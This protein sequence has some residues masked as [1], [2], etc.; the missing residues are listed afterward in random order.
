[1]YKKTINVR[2]TALALAFVAISAVAQP[3]EN[4]APNYVQVKPGTTLNLAN[5]FGLIA[6]KTT[7]AELASK[8]QRTTWSAT[9]EGGYIYGILYDIQWNWIYQ[10]NQLL[11]QSK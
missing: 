1:M 8:L 3:A 10:G 7:C 2:A 4:P 6:S 9:S 11:L 5:P